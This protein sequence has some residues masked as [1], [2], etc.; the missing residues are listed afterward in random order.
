M[1]GKVNSVID[2]EWV[3]LQINELLVVEYYSRQA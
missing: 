3:A 2:R 1:I